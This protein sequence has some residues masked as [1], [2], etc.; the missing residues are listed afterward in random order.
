[1]Y[2]ILNWIDYKDVGVVTERDGSTMVFEGH[3]EAYEYAKNKLN[4]N[5]KVVE[6]E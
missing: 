6:I 4:F 1:M 3:K 2:I 5:W